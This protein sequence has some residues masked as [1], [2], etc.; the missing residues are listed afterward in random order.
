MA[1]FTVTVP[2]DM[3][4]D[5]L[6]GFARR[7]NYEENIYNELG[8]QIPNPQTKAQFAKMQLFRWMRGIY[9][10]EKEAATVVARAA[11]INTATTDFDNDCTVT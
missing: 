7:F 3:V 2:T 8:E 10:E 11:V 9:I 4:D 5:L 1:D 6:N